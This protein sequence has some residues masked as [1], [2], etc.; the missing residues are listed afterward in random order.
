MASECSSSYE[1]QS[2]LRGHH[3]YKSTSMPVFRE[4]LVLHLEDKNRHTVAMMKD[5]YVVGMHRTLS[6]VCH[7]SLSNAVAA[8]AAKLQE[9]KAWKWC[10]SLTRWFFET[11]NV[12]AVILNLYPAYEWGQHLLRRA[13]IPANAYHMWF[14]KNNYTQII[15]LAFLQIRVAAV[16]SSCCC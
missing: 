8:S 7:C 13:F 9:S 4:E 12:F 10:R 15:T 2:V 11:Q 16:V 5:G 1:K 6:C 3:M 14:G